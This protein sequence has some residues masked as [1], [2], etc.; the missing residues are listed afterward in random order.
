MARRTTSI[1]PTYYN[2]EKD[3][4]LYGVYCPSFTVEALDEKSFYEVDD[5]FCERTTFYVLRKLTCEGKTAYG[6]QESFEFY[7]QAN[8]DSGIVGEVEFD[9]EQEARDYFNSLTH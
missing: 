4:K 1:R 8:Y 2:Y 9:D 5:S 7:D 3:G 6:I